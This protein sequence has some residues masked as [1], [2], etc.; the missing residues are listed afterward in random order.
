MKPPIKDT[1]SFTGAL[2]AV[3]HHCG[4]AVIRSILH[5]LPHIRR[6]REV[7]SHVWRKDRILTVQG[8]KRV[9]LHGA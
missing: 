6:P 8:F 3:M 9:G 4:L 7:Q 2:H 5:Q 1:E